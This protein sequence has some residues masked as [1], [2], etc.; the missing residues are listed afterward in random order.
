MIVRR[1]VEPAGIFR[2]DNGSLGNAYL[3][4][5]AAVQKFITDAV[6]QVD[7]I[8][9]DLSRFLGPSLFERE[10]VRFEITAVGLCL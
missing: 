1:S 3:V 8:R 5:S 7:G 9:A 10:S 2:E 4:I 6:R